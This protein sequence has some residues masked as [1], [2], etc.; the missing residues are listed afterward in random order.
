M[1][2]IGDFARIARVTIRALHHW[3]D[4][5]LLRP[6]RIDAWTGYRYYTL[7]QLPRLNRILALKDLGLS[8]E[9]I[10]HLLQRD[11]PPDEL[12]GMLRLKQAELEDQVRDV[13][14]RLARVEARLRQIEQED[15]MPD[16]EVI[17]KTV[18][19]LRVALVR[20]TIPNLNEIGAAVGRMFGLLGRFVGMSGAN[21]AGPGM[22][23]YF[24]QEDRQADLDIGAAFP[25]SGEL[26]AHEQVQLFELPAGT[27]ATLV[28]RGAFDGIQGAYKALFTWIE[29][30][31]YQANGAVR[32]VYLQF[33]ANGDPAHYV[34]E[35]QVPVERV[36]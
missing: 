35:I 18:E 23:L 9:Q 13:Q 4:L 28:H 27:M 25:Y 14:E 20:E 34:T 15:V 3:E 36:A 31:G 19:P 7:E 6:A 1:L 16:Y 29:A 10:G 22:C 11:L 30:N 21:F 17:V 26:P 5:D 33:D 12:R 24:D 2:K 8:L 32:E